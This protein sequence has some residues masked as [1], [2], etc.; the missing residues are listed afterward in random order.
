MIFVCFT[1]PYV[2]IATKSVNIH[3]CVYIMC[4]NSSFF[5]AIKNDL[6]MCIVTDFVF[7]G[8]RYFTSYKSF[9]F[10]CHDTTF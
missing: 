4:L 7:T 5:F 9:M 2:N 10:A 3:L 6:A 8:L 1:V